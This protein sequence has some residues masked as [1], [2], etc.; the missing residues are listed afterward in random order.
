[1]QLWF[2]QD[3]RAL[4]GPLTHTNT[5]FLCVPLL[6]LWNDKTVIKCNQATNK[7]HHL[8]VHLCPMSM[9]LLP[10]G[11]NRVILTRVMFTGWP[12]PVCQAAL[13]STLTAHGKQSLPIRLCKHATP[14]AV[15]GKGKLQV[16]FKL[17]IYDSLKSHLITFKISSNTAK[18]LKSLVK[19]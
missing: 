8:S 10:R 17:Q 16:R 6:S 11:H 1:M 4:I 18:S 15:M 5:P 14:R 13:A 12:P 7:P 3:W 19:S 9:E 2:Q